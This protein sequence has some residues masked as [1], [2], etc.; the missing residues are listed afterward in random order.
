M[1]SDGGALTAKAPVPA[2]PQRP[3]GRPPAAFTRLPRLRSGLAEIASMIVLLAL[4]LR[5]TFKRPISWRADFIEQCSILLKRCTAPLA[6]AVM[7]FGFGTIGTQAGQIFS[8]LGATDRLGQTFVTGSVR[9]LAGW[10]TAMIIAGVGGTAIA[11]DL[12]A[13]KIR[14]EIDALQVLG[15]DPLRQLVVPR[16]LALTVMTPLLF[17]VAVFFCTLSGVLVVLTQYDVTLAA[18]AATFT[19]NFSS[20]ELIGALLKSCTFGVIIAIVCCYK[21]LHAKGGAQGVGRAVNQ[22]VVMSFVTLWIFN[23]AFTSVLLAA[24]PEM[25]GLR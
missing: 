5:A 16:L 6:L 21:G 4:A 2:V 19:A 23:Y 24:F 13:R 22:A 1:S 17:L 14:E 8:A 7:A 20:P 18:F 25:Q 9:E 3:A 15:V 11:A 10:A 12:G